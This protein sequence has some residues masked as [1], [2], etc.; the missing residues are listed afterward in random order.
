MSTPSEEHALQ[1]G[2]AH[3][4]VFRDDGSRP[5][6][7][8]SLPELPEPP[9]WR[10]F[11]GT[12]PEGGTLP[13]PRSPD[14][15][16]ALEAS[17]RLGHPVGGTLDPSVVELVNAAIH[18]RRPLLVTGRPGTG[19]S[20]LARQIADELGL[21]PVL[22]WPVVSRTT[23]T[24]GLYAYDAIGRVREAPS[25]AGAADGPE[26]IGRYLTLG[27]LGTALLPWAR[28]RVLLIDELD[29]SDI[30]L[31]NDLL[32]VFEEGEFR[33]RELERT[34]SDAPEVRVRTADHAGTVGI[35]EGRVRC[36]EFPLVVITSN[37]ERDFPPAFRRRC[38][39]VR[40]P[41]PDVT[42]LTALVSAH[43]HDRQDPRA[44]ELIR[45]FLAPGRQSEGLAIDQ[46]LNA[47]HL[48]TNGAIN[49][50]ADGTRQLRDALWRSLSREPRT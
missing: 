11:S 1:P 13:T 10:R 20:S 28:P 38:L 3:W 50:G 35:R 33:I 4:W 21:G 15:A 29:K 16:E 5:G 34:A 30:D 46:L 8:G 22:W 42:R 26:Q 19:K 43:F 47:V 45:E 44:A 2:P 40:M 25:P 9:L 37:G 48:L 23:L 17:R 7:D 36:H 24:D 49:P 31:P 41:D 18:L 12:T 27:P 32:H 6:A 14:V 39:E